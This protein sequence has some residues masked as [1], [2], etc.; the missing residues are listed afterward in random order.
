M[1]STED[2]E[3]QRL[4]RQLFN[5]PT[6]LSAG[7]DDQLNTPLA[8]ILS[9]RIYPTL[10]DDGDSTD[11]YC[12]PLQ[13]TPVLKTQSDINLTRVRDI[14]LYYCVEY[15]DSLHIETR[16]HFQDNDEASYL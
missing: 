8:S 16:V 1:F 11:G 15:S 10:G 7:D 13:G 3:V 2:E 6:P 14:V 5:S 12:T 9:P 4:E